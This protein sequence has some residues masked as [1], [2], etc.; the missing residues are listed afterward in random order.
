MNQ[1]PL[2]NF[3]IKVLNN[4]HRV[5]KQ[6]DKKTTNDIT[7]FH[8]K[9]NSKRFVFS[10]NHYKT[11]SVICFYDTD[12][13]FN[14]DLV[15][16]C[17]TFLTL[18]NR[19]KTLP[20]I[21]YDKDKRIVLQS[22]S[23]TNLS[24]KENFNKDNLEDKEKLI[25]NLKN[26][27]KDFSFKLDINFF[28][29]IDKQKNILRHQFYNWET[30]AFISHKNT[31]HFRMSKDVKFTSGGLKSIEFDTKIK[32]KKRFSIRLLTDQLKYLSKFF[33]SDYEVTSYDN[34]KY[35]VFKNIYKPLTY[36]LFLKEK[37]VEPK[38]TPDSNKREENTNA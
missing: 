37:A 32:T 14:S 33:I 16:Q 27:K 34:R 29:Q 35:L 17:H 4:F 5:C 12:F 1:I 13:R 18:L 26:K 24:T 23:V 15:I 20:K 25:P 19:S 11:K 36:I 21:S 6:R 3:D 2:T 22:N 7:F 38:P 28:K 8:Y 30:S 9:K 31:L 10:A